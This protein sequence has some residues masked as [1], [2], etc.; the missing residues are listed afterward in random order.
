MKG[1]GYARLTSYSARRSSC[2]CYELLRTRI[3]SR[4]SFTT[5]LKIKGQKSQFAYI[6][7]FNGQAS[8][9][10]LTLNNLKAGAM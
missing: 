10:D 3:F 8:N 4:A 1:Q 2:N 6:P 5:L 9:N 7:P